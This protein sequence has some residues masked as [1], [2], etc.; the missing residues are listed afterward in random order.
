M[1]AFDLHL[2]NEGTHS[3]LYERLGAHIIRRGERRGVHFAVWAPNAERVSVVGPFNGWVPGV[4][5]MQ[6]LASSGLWTL[7]IPDL[8]EGT[9][10][11]YHVESRYHM[12]RADKADPFGFA[13][14]MPPGTASVVA[15]LDY[16]W[17]DA[18]WMAHRAQAALHI[19]PVSIY[20]VHLGSWRHAAQGQSLSYRQLAET[21]PLYV[22][23]LGFTHVE[24][25]PVMEHPLYRSWGYQT[26]G[27]FAPTGRFGSPQDFMY[28]VDRLHQAGIGV[29]LDWVPSH[30]PSDEH[31][32]GYFDGTHL[33]EHAD[34]R[35]GFH[36]DWKS[37]IFN[38]GRNEVRSFLLSSALFWLHKYHADA[39]RVDAVASMLYLDY[40]R[41]PGEWI[42]NP[43]GGRENLEA[44]AFLRQFN[45]EVY[46][47]FPGVQT[48]AE[49]ST[50]WPGVSRP[51]HTDGLG[52]GFKWD[53]GWMHDTLRYLSLDPI[54]R[55]AHH[56]D[57][58]FRGLYM[59]AENYTLPLSHDEVVH[60]KNSL[61]G[62]MP[63]DDWQKRAN[64][65]LL[66]ANQWTQPGKKL[67]FMGGEFGQR[68]EWDHDSALDWELLDRPEH[69]GLQ[70]LV[71]QL[72]RLY[73]EEP[74]LHELDHD[75][76]GFVYLLPDE[77]DLSVAAFMRRGADVGSEVVCIF[78]YTP[79]PRLQFSVGVPW[80]GVWREI[81]NTDALE[82]GGS[83]AGNLGFVRTQPI[84]LHDQPHSASL[85]L[86]PLAAVLLRH[87][88]V[89][90]AA[91]IE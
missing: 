34:P 66:L 12:Y 17:N 77:A 27:Y 52:F 25:L 35:Q 58:T 84:E 43:Q 64:L 14:E 55:K 40:S 78:N 4:H 32:L 57:L 62:K 79:V 7:F 61:L 37:L 22:R 88:P 56:H 48:F 89:A 91:E 69:A 42:P 38:Y 54:H 28:L 11:K 74:A 73:R 30:F 51:V 5:P 72:N 3:R 26:T 76:E 67:L 23:D 18:A 90:T 21:L 75:P 68:R 45:T 33:Y 49:E 85:V 15:S 86:P 19:S 24:F 8:G 36:P 39:L 9:L 13:H 29:I 31:G 59:F 60:G 44:I 63:G 82:F 87:D 2:F 70:R 41:Q 1:T 20:E 81:L 10:Y 47:S 53:M 6:P 83:G 71:R 80:H 46:R 65:R 50:A 16:H